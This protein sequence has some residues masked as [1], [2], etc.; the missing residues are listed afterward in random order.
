MAEAPDGSETIFCD[1]EGWVAM[2]ATSQRRGRFAR[3]IILREGG[4]GKVLLHARSSNVCRRHLRWDVRA[5]NGELIVT[6][7]AVRRRKYG[8][9]G[10][11]LHVC[12]AYHTSPAIKLKP[13]LDDPGRT[14]LVM[15]AVED[16]TQ[17]A[18]EGAEMCAATYSSYAGGSGARWSRVRSG[19]G[20]GG[21]RRGG[22]ASP[23]PSPSPSSLSRDGGEGSS[24]P[25]SPPAEAA[26]EAAAG[27]ACTEIEEDEPVGGA[28]AAAA[29]AGKA[30][31]GGTAASTA[32][33]APLAA[34][35]AAAAVAG[36]RGPGEC[37]VT[38][39]TRANM[40]LVCCVL[41]IHRWL[42][43]RDLQRGK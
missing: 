16:G 4:T 36:R 2:W 14:R 39:H 18:E 41:A 5:S 38:L 19:L 20:S 10:Y 24:L 1:T 12:A 3:S 13:D 28:A 35:V 42:L 22:A 25:P 34:A 6:A 30:A 26:A 15:W 7:Q 32:P 31:A 11:K 27:A 33:A 40:P 8:E 37:H 21:R 29:D 43:Q 9:A 17:K 23:S